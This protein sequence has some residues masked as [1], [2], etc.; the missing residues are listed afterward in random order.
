MAIRNTNLGGTDW[1]SE[2][3]A[4]A[5]L[6]DTFDAVGF[7]PVGTILPWAKSIT[8]VP[9]LLS[10]IFVECNGQTINDSDSPLDGQTIPDLNGDNRFLRGDSTS[11]LSGGTEEHNHQWLNSR[12]SWQSDGS[13]TES[14]N[15]PKR[16]EG[17]ATDFYPLEPGTTDA[18]TK[19]TDTKPPYYSVVWIMRIK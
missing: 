12:D 3:L 5:D 6:N 2:Y 9:S 4:S 11:G 15:I 17:S 10:G 13:T 8:G 14:L 19:N 1:G 16:D 18:Y 7:V